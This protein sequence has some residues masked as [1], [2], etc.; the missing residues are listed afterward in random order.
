MEIE[1]QDSNEHEHGTE[2]RV[3]EELDRGVLAARTAPDGY[4]EVHGHEHELP[5]HV[6]EHE[7]ECHEDAVHAHGEQLDHGE[8]ENGALLD[9]PAGENR[10]HGEQSRKGEQGHGDAVDTQEVLD[11]RLGNPVESLG[12]LHADRAHVEAHEQHH[13]QR[14]VDQ[15]EA[16]CDLLWQVR[17][18]LG[19]HCG[20]DRADKRHKYDGRQE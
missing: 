6:E 2:E 17:S 12:E 15:T 10:E 5:E 11:A 13:G 16:E 18:R 7:V 19:Q 3:E 1:S 9:L 14:K 20:H 4:Q 8:V